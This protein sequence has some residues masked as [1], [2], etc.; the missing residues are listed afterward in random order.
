MSP[1]DR[2][3]SHLNFY[4][5]I[6]S[7]RQV[8]DMIFPAHH[9]SKQIQDNKAT[10]NRPRSNR[11]LN[12][13]DFVESSY[14]E[15]VSP[16]QLLY[17]REFR[18]FMREE[19]PSKPKVLTDREVCENLGLEY[20]ES[21]YLLFSPQG[22]AESIRN[23][24]E[25]SLHSQAFVPYLDSPPVKQVDFG[26][27]NIIC[28]SQIPELNQA[29][30][31]IQNNTFKKSMTSRPAPKKEYNFELKPVEEC[32]EH[33]N[34]SNT[35]TALSSNLSSSKTSELPHCI[36][37]KTLKYSPSVIQNQG[38]QASSLGISGLISNQTSPIIQ[39]GLTWAEPKLHQA[40]QVEQYNTSHSKY[41]SF[42]NHPENIDL[43]EDDSI[44]SDSLFSQL[45]HRPS[46][47]PRL[48]TDIC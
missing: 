39:I 42:I 34:A 41:T 16:G 46:I 31:A 22:K 7:L 5:N 21:G 1:E 4:R 35:I 19:S 13:S 9:N 30:Q 45:S 44:S 12:L 2:H 29:E 28:N 37:N 36:P 11:L 40:S 8:P 32:K 38:S 10:S 24:G 25:V 23:S 27:M 33:S 6:S 43:P 3:L 18:R 15:S 14:K 47:K 17:I 48:I 20:E 26:K